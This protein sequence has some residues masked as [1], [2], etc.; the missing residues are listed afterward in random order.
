MSS[1][2]IGRRYRHVKGRLGGRCGNGGVFYAQTEARTRENVPH[3]VLLGLQYTRDDAAGSACANSAACS[4]K[5]V[6]RTETASQ[7]RCQA[8]PS[9]PSDWL[10]DTA[11]IVRGVSCCSMRPFTASPS[12]RLVVS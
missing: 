1:N 10:V 3:V 12:A 4:T 11:A 7:R 6:F 9:C 8:G 2:I 5:P